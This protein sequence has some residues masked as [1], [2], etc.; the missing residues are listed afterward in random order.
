MISRYGAA[1]VSGEV[2]N[3]VITIG[4]LKLKT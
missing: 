4:F 2:H 1:C 3:P